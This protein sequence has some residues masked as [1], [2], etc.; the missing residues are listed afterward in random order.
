MT[1]VFEALDEIDVGGIRRIVGNA[2]QIFNNID[3]LLTT[4]TSNIGKEKCVVCYSALNETENNFLLFQTSVPHSMDLAKQYKMS[5]VVWRT[6]LTMYVKRDHESHQK[7]FKVSL[8]L[9][10]ACL[11]PHIPPDNI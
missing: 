1:D 4:Q 6:L 5:S 7:L 2:T 8:L 9:I 10:A 3:T 11:H